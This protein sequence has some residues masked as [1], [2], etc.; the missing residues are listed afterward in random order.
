MLSSLLDQHTK[1]NGKI[2]VSAL[3]TSIGSNIKFTPLDSKS[4]SKDISEYLS[5]E[6]FCAELGVIYQKIKPDPDFNTFEDWEKHISQKTPI[7]TPKL[8]PN[9]PIAEYYISSSH[10]TYLKGHQL[11]GESTIERYKKVLE[12]GCRC[13]ELDCWDGAKE[14]I[15][16]H[17]Y[18]LTTKI[19]FKDVLQTIKDCAFTK[20]PYPLILSIENHCSGSYQEMMSKSL[21]SILG[22]F[23][24]YPGVCN[25]RKATLNDLK[26][27]IIIKGKVSPK[28]R[29]N[30]IKGV[31]PSR[32]IKNYI[33]SLDERN[34]ILSKS[35]VCYTLSAITFLSTTHDVEKTA[36]DFDILSLNEKGSELELV[37]Y[38]KNNLIRLY[39]Q[40]MRVDS[41]NYNPIVGWNKGCQIIALNWQTKDKWMKLNNIMFDVK[42]YR[43]KTSESTSSI[44]IIIISGRFLTDKTPNVSPKVKISVLSSKKCKI[45]TTSKVNNNGL[46][47]IWNHITDISL[48]S[49]GLVFVLFEVI[50]KNRSIYNF[51]AKVSDLSTGYYWIP[52]DH[53][54]E[55]T[56]NNHSP[57]REPKL[58]VYV[59]KS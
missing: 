28:D 1:S 45:Y 14:P 32:S 50:N 46:N 54:K 41:S 20:T 10:N 19:L 30:R 36:L 47:P 23:L 18:T 11:V 48:E 15:I 57:H 39:P 4:T 26:Y 21:K 25:L 12:E 43:N 6:I 16:Y 53:T 17:G 9:R 7:I 24:L 37:K 49:L 35:M 22:D 3:L 27:K 55:K 58:L 5:K 31:Y 38:S 34:A 8:N 13:I 33:P 44:K 59:S 2:N 40:N 29:Q 42:G 51:G 56:K 52:L